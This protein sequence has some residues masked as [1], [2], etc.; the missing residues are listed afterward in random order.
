M[1]SESISEF[2]TS[3]IE[4]GDFPSVVYLVAEEGEIVLHD[5][6]GNAVVE[7]EQIAATPDTIYDLASMTKVLVTGLLCGMLIETGELSLD[8][9]ASDLLP[10]LGSEDKREITIEQLLTHTSGLPAWLPLYL[11]VGDPAEVLNAID[12]TP[13][14]TEPASV[15]YSDLNF[16]ILGKIVER[17]AGDDLDKAAGM[18]FSSMELQ[19]TFF[20]P[21]PSLREGIAAAEHG[22]N[23]ERDTC[24]EQFPE[25]LEKR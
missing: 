21:D 10:D 24:R 5:A 9:R 12:D 15:V 2:L 1:R 23:F 17:I 25:L 7:P 19:N 6:L 14:R 11:C 18:I 13:L 16:I 4:A 22:N 8:D 20:R 3:R